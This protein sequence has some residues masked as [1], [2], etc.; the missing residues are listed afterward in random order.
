ML[1]WDHGLEEQKEKKK[2][3]LAFLYP[4]LHLVS[5]QLQKSAKGRGQE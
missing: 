3:D 4:A 1:H 5:F 2:K